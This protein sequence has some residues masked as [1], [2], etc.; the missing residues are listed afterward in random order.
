MD[1]CAG[2]GITVDTARFVP[3]NTF[4]KDRSMTKERTVKC[5]ELVLFLK[6]GGAA[7]ING[8]K[9]PIT[10]GSVRF[11]RPGDRVY[12]Y[13]FNEIYVLHFDVDNKEKGKRIFDS[14]P[15]FINLP[16]FENEIR[17]YQK[18]ITALVMQ[19][20]FESIHS[21]WEILGSIKA[22]LELQ[23]NN[24]KLQ[25]TSK[26]K[27]YMD[28]HYSQ[29]FTLAELAQEFHMH[30]VYMHRKFKKDVGMTP[31]QYLKQIRLSK[32]KAYLLTTDLSVDDISER[33]GF[34][35]SSYFIKVFKGQMACTPYQFRNQSAL[36]I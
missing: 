7:V 24:S 32:A 9:Y 14:M 30:P 5:Y 31:L 15:S 13:R 18:L 27:K 23:Q 22:Q 26:I 16:S 11:H 2:I 34:C 10:A 33:C 1:Y 29:Q 19:D 20:D 25:I 6:D 8:T 21:L 12:S 17:M 4:F 3:A 35:N 28:D 36:Q